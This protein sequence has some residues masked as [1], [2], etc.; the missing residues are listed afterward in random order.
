MPWTKVPRNKI[1]P[2]YRGFDSYKYG[3][4]YKPGHGGGGG[5]TGGGGG[6]TGNRGCKL[7]AL[8]AL[9]LVSLPPATAAALWLVLDRL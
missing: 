8:V 2:P 5:G 4:G 7:F 3:K 6:G 9:T 1:N